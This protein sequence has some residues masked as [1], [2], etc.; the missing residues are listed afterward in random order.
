MTNTEDFFSFPLLLFF[1]SEKI[2]KTKTE[3]NSAGK[4]AS[5]KPKDL[6]ESLTV[7]II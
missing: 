1:F 4:G 5:T 7:A 2:F 3:K 6:N